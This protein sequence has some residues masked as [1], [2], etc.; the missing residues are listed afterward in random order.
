MK[1]V[2]LSL[3]NANRELLKQNGIE[4]PSDDFIYLTVV[5]KDPILTYSDTAVPPRPT[6]VQIKLPYGL[7]YRDGLFLCKEGKREQFLDLIYDS[8]L[9]A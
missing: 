4:E 9:G 2:V 7:K 1:E 3:R 6:P 8:G 5:M